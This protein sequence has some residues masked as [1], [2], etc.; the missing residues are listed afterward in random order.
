M[1]RLE[2]GL[3]DKYTAS[4]GRIFVTGI[5]AL[6]RLPLIQRQRDLAAGLNTAGYIT[7]YRGSPLGAYD[8][9]LE[10]AKA[11]LDAHHI[12]HKPGVNE[13]LAATACWARS[14]SASAARAATMAYS[15]SGTAKAPASTGRAT[16][17]AT[18]TCSAPP[19]TAACC[20]CWATTISASLSTTAHQSEYAMVDAL[21]PVLNPA[22]VQEILEYGLLGIAMSRF[23]GGWVALKCVH[24]T[25]ESTASIPVDPALPDIACRMTSRRRPTV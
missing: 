25:V 13:D 7:G 2:V 16:P 19:R 18:A 1:Q 14:R 23:T 9:Q 24:D 8:Q 12:V 17:S 11:H 15:R 4:R 3:D 22:G 5:Q 6:V 20:C 21:V 10:R